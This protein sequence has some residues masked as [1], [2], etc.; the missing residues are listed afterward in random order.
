MHDFL[1]ECHALIL[2]PKKSDPEWN[3]CTILSD[4]RTM[5]N[6]SQT[7]CVQ[8][9]QSHLSL[10]L[11]QWRSCYTDGPGSTWQHGPMRVA[12]HRWLCPPRRPSGSPSVG[13]PPLQSSSA[14]RNTAGPYSDGHA[15]TRRPRTHS[16]GLWGLVCQQTVLY[17]IR[18]NRDTGKPIRA[19]PLVSH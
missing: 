18:G 12:W 8:C 11:A 1:G 7:K 13:R 3:F 4:I 19:I 15:H 10:E 14:R 2:L 16:P 5:V 6:C 17:L 9:V